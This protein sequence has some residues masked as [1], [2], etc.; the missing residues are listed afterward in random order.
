[1]I[2]ILKDRFAL[3]KNFEILNA[4]VLK[5]D[6]QSLISKELVEFNLK[7]AKIV[8]NLPYYI[9]TPIIM[10]LLEDRLNLKSITVMVQKEVAIRLTE[11]PGFKET[12]AITY[13]IYYYT[14]PKLVLSVPKTSFIP[15][16]EVDSAV[17]KLDLLE[18]PRVR[19]LNEKL[20]F[21]IIKISFMKKRKTLVNA[22][23]SGKA[24][25]D[26]QNIIKMLENLGID[27][28][29]RGEKLSI[30][31]YVKIADYIESFTKESGD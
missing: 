15:I 17:I 26:K 19:V 24:L 4:D 29:I 12:G 6:L 23:E 16:P 21:N 28:K 10:K 8:A 27:T 5:V 13:S 9:T 1:M 11:I 2:N 18:K 30:E 22:L 3:Y 20:F 14:T 25:Q 31:E 7:Q